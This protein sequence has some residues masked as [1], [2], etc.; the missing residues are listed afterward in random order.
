VSVSWDR[1][2]TDATA[3]LAIAWREI[4][5]EPIAAPVKSAMA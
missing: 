3:I 5:G 1:T 4:G 2:V